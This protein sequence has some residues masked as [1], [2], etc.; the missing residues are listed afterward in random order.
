M[1][2]KKPIPIAEI[3][4]GLIIVIILMVVA[5]PR[6]IHWAEGSIIDNE[7]SKLFYDLGTAQNTAIQNIH[8][9]WIVFQ[10]TSEYMIFEDINGNGARDGGEPVRKTKLD[11][12]VQFGINLDPPIQ[13]VWGTATIAQPID[14]IG[15]KKKFYFM[16][17]GAASSTG[18]VYLIALTDVGNS[19]ADIRAVKV[20]GANGEISVVRFSPGDSPPWK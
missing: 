10:G 4:T 16:P 8:K 17:S 18:A 5:L 20:I 14:F 7:A 6:F 3:I 9:V 12:G 1:A 11:P 19:D 13:N 15:G 2:E